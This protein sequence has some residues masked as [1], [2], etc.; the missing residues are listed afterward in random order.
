MIRSHGAIC[1][2]RFMNYKYVAGAVAL[3]IVILVANSEKILELYRGTV[4]KQATATVFW[5]GEPATK[6][7]GF[8][9]NGESAWDEGWFENFGGFDDPDC[10]KGYYPC[11]FTPKENPFYIALPYDDI[12]H[13]RGRKESAA[14]IPWNNPAATGTLLKNRWVEVRTNRKS[15]FGQWEDVGPFEED[16]VEY[17]FGD[18][19]MPKNML[20]ERAGI[21]LSPAMRDC[22]SIDGSA[23]VEWRHVE[24]QDVSQ[25]PWRDI[26]TR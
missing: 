24:E 10:R 8:I 21:D 20:G 17:V 23:Q 15:C 4:W 5:V 12:D 9:Q 2:T 6:A 16:D 11:G 26:I 18:A 14:R 19:R 1:Y 25:G 7:N 22:L 13:E 3:G